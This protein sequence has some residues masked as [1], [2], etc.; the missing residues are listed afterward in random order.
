MEKAVN[1]KKTEISDLVAEYKELVNLHSDEVSEY[2]K[3]EY[4]FKDMEEDFNDL[5]DFE[6][7][8]HFYY[9]LGV[10]FRQFVIKY[11]INHDLIKEET[12]NIFLKQKPFGYLLK[13]KHDEEPVNY[14]TDNTS[15]INSEEE[16]E[17]IESVRENKQDEQQEIIDDLKKQI[18]I[19]NKKQQETID[20]LKEE[21]INL[22]EQLKINNKNNKNNLL[23]I[24]QQ[25]FNN[26]NAK[27]S[28]QAIS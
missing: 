6:E 19:N 5:D 10:E 1:R 13:E 26:Q 17:M 11:N 22:K 28:L 27:Y 21:M 16:K 20:R 25:L 8:K 14:D 9:D 4:Y 18:Q 12:I 24:I 2:L 3:N 15:A 7:L 23:I